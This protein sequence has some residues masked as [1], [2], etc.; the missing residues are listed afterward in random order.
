VFDTETRVVSVETTWLG[1]GDNLHR[2]YLKGRWLSE[3]SFTGGAFVIGLRMLT[4]DD[5]VV[6]TVTT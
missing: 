2:W 5:L 6:I 4:V 1:D 3:L